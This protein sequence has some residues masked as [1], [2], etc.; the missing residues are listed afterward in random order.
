MRFYRGRI[1]ALVFSWSALTLLGAFAIPSSAGAV[2]TVGPRVAFGAYAAGLSGAGTQ[3]AQFER[4]LGTKVAIAS[5]FR[6]W[7]DIFPDSAQLADANSGHT[8]LV[9]W[10]LGATSATRFSTFPAHRHDAYLAAEAAT[11]RAYG[12]PLYVRPWAEMNGDWSAFQ[13]TP[14]GSA[15]A[16]G[17][18]AQFIA[19]WRYLAT[20]FRAHGATNVRWVFNPTTDTYPGTT[21][22][23][24]IW[25]GVAYVDVLGLDGYNWGTGGVFK[26]RSFSDIYSAQYQR[27]ASL[28][29]TL[30]VW[31]CEFGS[32]EPT[33]NDGA[34]I[35][36]AHT[37]SSWYAGVWSFLAAAPRVRALVIF[38]VRKERDWRVESY[39][40][41]LAS[42][43]Q[44]AVSAALTVR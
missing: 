24:S 11:A 40:S 20:F 25:P 22:I 5:S 12:K 15:P 42:V 21:D 34:P 3:L 37:K 6:G 36:T 14:S 38:D 43:R 31:I 44:Y 39:P 17:T 29:S 18:S 33:K 19:A 27:L 35:D 4:V 16:G 10:D 26:W 1:R 8:L 41:A 30:P 9:A 23:R 28:S 13:P 7:G 32:K 2:T